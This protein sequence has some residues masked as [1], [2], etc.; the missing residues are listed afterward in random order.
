MHEKNANNSTQ[1]KNKFFN[2]KLQMYLS[3]KKNL[4]KPKPKLIYIYCY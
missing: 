4:P 3:S 1:M 2:K